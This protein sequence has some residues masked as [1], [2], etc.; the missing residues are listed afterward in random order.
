[1]LLFKNKTV[2]QRIMCRC[3]IVALFFPHM[4]TLIKWL[5]YALNSSSLWMCS[6]WLCM[7]IRN[8]RCNCTCRGYFMMEFHRGGEIYCPSCPGVCVCVWGMRSMNRRI[9]VMEFHPGGDLLTLLSSCVC[10]C[11]CVYSM[12]MRRS[13]M[14][15]WT[16]TGTHTITHTHWHTHTNTRSHTQTH[17]HTNTH[18]HTHTQTYT[19]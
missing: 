4:F 5:W 13:K 16:N 9:F 8:L 19:H 17:T 7:T 11:V 3:I 12:A 1:M 6:C 2:S 10:V 15:R 18:K 14:D